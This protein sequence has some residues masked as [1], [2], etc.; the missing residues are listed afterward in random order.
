[1]QI[2]RLSGTGDEKPAFDWGTTINTALGAAGAYFTF[3][4][5]QRPGST[6]TTPTQTTPPPTGL[7]P[8]A[9]TLL[10]AGGVALAG[11]VIYSLTKKK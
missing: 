6:P 5:G 1:M 9:K 11:I 8:T 7:S 3:R 2:H 4:S 10:L